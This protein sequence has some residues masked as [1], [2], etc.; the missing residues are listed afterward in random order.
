MSPIIV[1]LFS[2]ITGDTRQVFI[3]GMYLT[4][5][6]I[7]YRTAISQPHGQA[8]KHKQRRSEFREH[9]IV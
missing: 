1:D 2:K 3:E 8:S 5:E 6:I 7:T 4:P 9:V